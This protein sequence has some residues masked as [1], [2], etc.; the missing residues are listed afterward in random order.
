MVQAAPR[1]L[2]FYEAVLRSLEQEGFKDR[3]V[4]RT[5]LAEEQEDAIEVLMVW[6]EEEAETCWVDASGNLIHGPC[7]GFGPGV[8]LGLTHR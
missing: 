4:L 8:P 2:A 1:T 6:R 7:P 5:F 3:R